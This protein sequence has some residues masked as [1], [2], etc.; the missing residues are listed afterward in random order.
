MFVCPN[1]GANEQSKSNQGGDLVEIGIDFGTTNS[2]AIL[3]FMSN[4]K[5]NHVMPFDVNDAE[6]AFLTVSVNE[7]M[8]PEQVRASL[9]AQ[10]KWSLKKKANNEPPA[11]FR[12]A[13]IHFH[14]NGAIHPILES[15]IYRMNGMEMGAV[16]SNGTLNNS[17]IF[18]RY[19]DASM[20]WDGEADSAKHNQAA[21]LENFALMCCVAARKHAGTELSKVRFKVS[22]PTSLP[23]NLVAVIKSNW[24]DISSNLKGRTGLETEGDILDE[25]KCNFLSESLCAAV[26]CIV[27]SHGKGYS[28]YK[29]VED[30][31]KVVTKGFICIDIGG[32]SIDVAFVKGEPMSEGRYG[33]N[34]HLSIPFAGQYIMSAGKNESN[35]QEINDFFR[36][37]LEKILRPDFETVKEPN[38]SEYLNELYISTARFFMKYDSVNSSKKELFPVIVDSALGNFHIMINEI[39]KVGNV[40]RE[41]VY[42]LRQLRRYGGNT[43]NKQFARVKLGIAGVMYFIGDVLGSL[44]KTGRFEMS[45]DEL[46]IF[47]AGNGS[48]IIEWTMDKEESGRTEKEQRD[49]ILTDFLVAG[50]KNSIADAP[51]DLFLSD[52]I[53]TSIHESTKPKMEAAY[54]LINSDNVDQDSCPEFIPKELDVDSIHFFTGSKDKHKLEKEVEKLLKKARETKP[55]IPEKMKEL[56]CEDHKELIDKL[57]EIVNPDYEYGKLADVMTAFLNAFYELSPDDCKIMFPKIAEN[58]DDGIVETIQEYL[59]LLQGATSNKMT[60]Q[61]PIPVRSYNGYAVLK[62]VMEAIR[63]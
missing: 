34:A 52:T 24:A 43:V 38:A 62:L 22:Y 63:K 55:E 35:I 17:I 46:L 37:L 1:E 51:T 19:F 12:S 59:P 57:T 50:Y 11:Y 33:I 6:S 18:N 54:G 32:G 29:R 49:S 20:K 30:N 2:V 58:G 53:N 8:F 7:D 26:S 13:L 45:S 39:K 16:D 23:N 25:T 36:P 47:F 4:G 10:R 56:G 60:G 44:I 42:Y 28:I 41:L 5:E 21:F 31:D 15:N 14:N 61:I 3:R 48:K 9:T 40:N 27:G